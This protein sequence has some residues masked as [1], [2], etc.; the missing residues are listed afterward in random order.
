MA[1][2]TPTLDDIESYKKITGELPGPT[3]LVVY[4]QEDEDKFLEPIRELITKDLSEPYSIYV[5]RYFLFQ[6]PELC[7]MVSPLC[8]PTLTTLT[9]RRRSTRRRSSSS[10]SSSASRS[11][12]AAAP[13]AA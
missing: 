4:R 10:A 6:W 5:Y 9:L 8:S 12:T 3:D 7:W 2:V 11:A 1:S 13:T